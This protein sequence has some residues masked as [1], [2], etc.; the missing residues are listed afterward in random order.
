MGLAYQ[1]YPNNCYFEGQDADERI[2]LL[3]RAHPV[4]N[5]TWII[6]A[7]AIFLLPF[8]IPVLLPFL[9]LPKI[10][11]PQ[12]LILMM[13]IINY[14]IVLVI[15]FEGFLGWYFN[16]DII[17]NKKIVDVDFHSLMSKNIDL[18]PLSSIQEASGRVAGILGIIFHYGPVDVQTAGAN[19]SVDFHNVP[20]PNKVADIIMDAVDKASKK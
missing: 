11:L 3:L 15:V 8:I 10:T 9:S 5:L 19:V 13:L 12:Y 17:T 1:E 18:A 4:T 16:V 2:I 14:L 6:P 20:E 7:V